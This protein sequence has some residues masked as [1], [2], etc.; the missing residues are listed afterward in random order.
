MKIT[1]IGISDRVPE[2]TAK[3]QRLIQS[4]KFFA[5]GS[6]HKQLVADL[7]PAESSW[8]DII[9][10]LSNLY[11]AIEDACDDWVIFASGDPLFYGIGITLKREFPDVKIDILP[12]FNSLQLLAHQ[13]QLPYGEFQTISLTG[14]SFDAF[15]K[16]LIQGKERMGILT[17]RKNTPTTIAH[18]MLDFGYTNYSMYFGECLGGENQRVL[19]LSIEDAA[20]MTFQHPNCFYL[21]KTDDVIPLKGI[22]ESAFEPLEGRPKMITKMPIRMATL[23]FMELNTK[24]VFWDVG[25]CT[26]SVSID[27]R[28][29][30]PH[31]KVV[32]FEI[33]KESEGIIHRNAQKFK[34]P[35]IEVLIGDYLQVQKR[36][37]KKPDAVF[38][39]GYGGRMEAVLDDIHLYLKEK[40]L[41]AFNSVSES[42]KK[43]FVA[44]CHQRAYQ[45]TQ[46]VQMSVDQ[47][48]PITILIAQKPDKP[49]F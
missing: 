39:G 33:R 1:I 27:A 37:L 25:A 47:F 21:E 34:A 31:L 9:V 49:D 19:K 2:F 17:D 24:K 48:N 41:I 35:G 8:H 16:A 22:V 20:K 40:G 30:H 29:N 42:S 4:V 7:L 18:R 32:A 5:G 10:P 3:E 13:F 36:E 11:K 38:L 23:A 28:L 46:S 43:R 6:R 45:I 12:D 15:D 26:G 44:W 14:R